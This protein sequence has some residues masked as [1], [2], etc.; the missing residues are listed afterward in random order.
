MLKAYHYEHFLSLIFVVALWK[1]LE[2]NSDWN[3]NISD[4]LVKE[5]VWKYL[6]SIK[7]IQWFQLK[8]PRTSLLVF[9]TT[10]KYF[11][12][13]EKNVID[14]RMPLIYVIR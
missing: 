13:V 3:L 11:E 12:A 7:D 6:I 8:E 5:F 1:R 14:V 4:N 10:E 2:V 9:S